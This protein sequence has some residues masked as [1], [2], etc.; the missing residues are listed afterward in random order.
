MR[1]FVLQSPRCSF[2]ATTMD[3]LVRLNNSIDS[4]KDRVELRWKNPS[5]VVQPVFDRQHRTF[6]SKDQPRII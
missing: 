1:Y 5:D 2:S 4:I 6:R 3:I